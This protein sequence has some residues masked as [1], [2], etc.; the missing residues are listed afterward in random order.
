MGDFY[1]RLNLV[2]EVL[3]RMKL[4]RTE[5]LIK[6]AEAYRGAMAAMPGDLLVSAKARLGLAAV[7]EDQGEWDKAEQEYK[8]LA[9]KP[10]KYAGTPLAELAETRLKE[11][12][13]RRSAPR[14]AA[15]IP[16]A[17]REATPLTPTGMGFE[18]LL[19]PGRA[20]SEFPGLILNPMG[21]TQPATA[22]ASTPP[23]SFQLGP[24]LVPPTTQP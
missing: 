24:L 20:P 2:P 9:A 11:L 17:R 23:P 6:A 8:E 1:E 18:G 22:P 3:D 16:V 15:G 14:L 13:D 21:T 5:C 4:S 19:G 12:N 10:G 7:F